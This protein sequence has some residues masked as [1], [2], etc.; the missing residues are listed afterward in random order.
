M[1][2]L[3][4]G[5]VVRALRRRR[6]WRQEDCARRANLHRSTWSLVERGQLDRITLAKLRQCLAVLE[7]RLE[8]RPQWRGPELDRLLD[9]AHASLQAAWADRL[10]Q[11]DWDVRVEVSFN[12]YGDRGRIDLLAWHPRTR[13]LVVAEVKSEL[14]DAQDTLG[15]LDVKVPSRDASRQTLAGPNRVRCVRCSSSTRRRQRGIGSPGLRPSSRAFSVRGRA[16]VSCLRHPDRLGASLLVL[17][18]LRNAGEGRVK[19]PGTHR[20]RT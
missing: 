2:D 5:R 8:L 15:R 17:S 19:Q 6:G 16:A 4:L 12:H 14:V 10:R 13:S 11:W 20:V 9:A 18:D 7:I 3:E 1:R